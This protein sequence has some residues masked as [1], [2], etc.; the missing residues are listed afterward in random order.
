MTTSF[1]VETKRRRLL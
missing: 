1:I